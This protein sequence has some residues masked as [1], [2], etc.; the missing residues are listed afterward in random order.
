MLLLYSNMGS[1]IWYIHT[2]VQKMRP[3]THTHTYSTTHKQYNNKCELVLTFTCKQ[4]LYTEGPCILIRMVLLVKYINH[5]LAK[6]IKYMKY[7]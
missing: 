1:T 2:S 4:Q 7:K 5:Y 3:N 6:Q